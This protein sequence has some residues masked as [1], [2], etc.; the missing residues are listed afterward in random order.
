MSLRRAWIRKTDSCLKTWSPQGDLNAQPRFF[1]GK[2]GTSGEKPAQAGFSGTPADFQNRDIRFT[3]METCGIG[4]REAVSAMPLR[5]RSEVYFGLVGRFAR[6]W[7]LGAGRKPVKGGEAGRHDQ[8]DITIMLSIFALSPISWRLY[9]GKLLPFFGKMEKTWY[10][11]I[12]F[13]QEMQFS[14]T[15]DSLFRAFQT[16]TVLPRSILCMPELPQKEAQFTD[17]LPSGAAEDL[18][19][20]DMD[21]CWVADRWK[22]TVPTRRIPEPGVLTPRW[23][24]SCW[25]YFKAASSYRRKIWKELIPSVLSHPGKP[26]PGKIG[27]LQNSIS[28]TTIHSAWKCGTNNFFLWIFSL[29]IVTIMHA[30]I[31]KEKQWWVFW[32]ENQ[33]LHNGVHFLLHAAN[34]TKCWEGQISSR[35]SP[36]IRVEGFSLCPKRLLTFISVQTKPEYFYSMV[37]ALQK[38]G[39][40]NLPKIN[41]TMTNPLLAFHAIVTEAER[42]YEELY[43]TSCINGYGMILTRATYNKFVKIKRK[44][45]N[46][47]PSLYQFADLSKPST[48]AAVASYRFSSS[49]KAPSNWIVIQENRK[50][51]VTGWIPEIFYN[52]FPQVY[53]FTC[54]LIHPNFESWL[55]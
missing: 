18:S 34:Q 2:I 47:I 13:V 37:G 1:L 46:R 29:C 31:I 49:T 36:P 27:L 38:R 50:N 5:Q 14:Q 45:K 55:Y 10:S 25:Q 21:G 44:K 33:I 26:F 7:Q 16:A 52:R 6:C 11:K 48:P 20:S 41:G 30:E 4:A 35:A 43:K 23:I 51:L 9:F 53:I 32:K 8:A 54:N 19:H 22:K 17:C 42:K 3:K 15:W 24:C 40:A 39:P 28:E 12:E